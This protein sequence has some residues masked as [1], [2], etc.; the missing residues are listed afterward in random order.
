MEAFINLKRAAEKS[1]GGNELQKLMN[2]VVAATREAGMTLMTGGTQRPA[3]HFAGCFLRLKLPAYGFPDMDIFIPDPGKKYADFGAKKP[4]AQGTG[5]VSGIVFDNKRGILISS[6]S[7]S[8]PIGAEPDF[9]IY[10]SVC[11][12]LLGQEDRFSNK[13]DVDLAQN[14]PRYTETMVHWPIEDTIDQDRVYIAVSRKAGYESLKKDLMHVLKNSLMKDKKH[15]LRDDKWK[16]YII[17]WDL[18]EEYG[19]TVSYSDISDILSE[20]YPSV[21]RK[22]GPAWAGLFDARNCENYYENA[23][24]LIR[25][26]YKKY[27]LPEK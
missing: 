23:S 11:G 6:D 12:L 17:V 3:E 1:M 2:D 19:N 10:Q 13:P 7:G 15:A 24:A 25:G 9:R 26:G 21:P 14:P 4:F 8:H 27:L 22:K 20:A 16:F 18:R 5:P